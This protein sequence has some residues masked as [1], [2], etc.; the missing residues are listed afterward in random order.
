MVNPV[1][2]TDAIVVGAGF[3]GIYMMHKL[4][5]LGL[6]AIGLEAGEGVG[7][8][9]YWNTYPGARCDC[10]SME[11]AY[12]FDR[13]MVEQWE[14]KER[15]PSQ[16]QILEYL[17]YAADKL[18]VR[19]QF[20]FGRR[21]V[22]AR[23]DDGAG[24]WT[25]ET[26]DGSAYVAKYFITAVGCLSTSQVPEFPGLSEYRG[27][28]Y[29]TASWPKDGV[30]FTGKHVGVIGTG[31][32]GVQVIPVIAEDAE[33]LTVFQRTPAFSLDCG[34]R[35]LT[36]EERREF[37][38]NFEDYLAKSRACGTGQWADTLEHSALDHAE[39]QRNAVYEDR[40]NRH[41]AVDLLLA[42]PDLFTNRD[43][44]ETIAEFFRSKIRA[45]VKDAELAE[46]L[47][48]RTYPLG[49]KR[50]T[51][52]TGYFRTYNRDNVELVNL[53]EEPLQTFTAQGIVTGEQEH[54]LDA[55]V[56]ATGF[57]AVSGPLL[58]IQ[59][60]G[61]QGVKL[62]DR[63]QGGPATYLGISV[64]GFPNMFML[65]GPGSP[66]VLTNVVCAIEQHVEWTADC[67]RFLEES[68]A[69]RFE[70]TEDSVADWTN[71]INEMATQTLYPE[72][73]SWYTGANIPGKPRVMLSYVGG[74]H[75]YREQCDEVAAAGYRGFEIS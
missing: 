56:F 34:N 70:A 5:E 25:V 72:G 40:W 29:H 47:S 39:E 16:D 19:E 7:G 66:N 55:V 71:V 51:L 60:S 24:R 49:A 21:V 2:S 59:I 53:R 1:K 17:N 13:E 9:W 69:Q 41:R 42:Y 57:D 8:T 36:D 22:A 26:D 46:K 67:L 73:D 28:T 31:S 64:D 75:T 45:V 11:Y 68:G 33:S 35:D 74:L 44:N 20:L 18:G 58:N 14:H 65:T 54:Q 52:D 3:S 6:G 4:H 27:A 48:P 12:T 50:I 61:S 63:W 62:A 23:Y 10:I 32:S 15:Y 38:D 30:D 37:K 43:A